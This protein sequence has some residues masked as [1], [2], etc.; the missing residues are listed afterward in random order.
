MLD[1]EVAPLGLSAMLHSSPW[2][3]G[4]LGGAP[5]GPQAFKGRRQHDVTW[6]P[7]GK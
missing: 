6:Y 4:E 3:G 1:A 7:G 5:P 2:E